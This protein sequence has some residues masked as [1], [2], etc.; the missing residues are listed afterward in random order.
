MQEQLSS[1]PLFQGMSRD[2]LADVA[3]WAHLDTRLLKPARTI[4]RVGDICRS[5]IF[6]A[7]GRF[8]VTT[9]AMGHTYQITET[10]H[11]PEVI[12]PERV[13]GLTQ[14]YSRTYTA[15]TPTRIIELEKPDML[16]LIEKYLVFRLNLL[17]LIS[18][19][20]QK[21][22]RNLWTPAPQT[23]DENILHFVAK[24]CD[25]PAGSIEVKTKMTLLA[26]ELG[27]S[28]LDVSNALHR[29]SDAGLI[30][31]QRGII[32]IPDLQQALRYEPK[33]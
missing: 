13:F 8:Q 14:Q 12:E 6:V 28:R 16:A 3:K 2:D 26:H 27:V 11:A 19:K 25:I 32:T 24:H 4:V 17:A 18:T 21:L 33:A 31:L 20:A 29:L 22:H 1:L 15:L 10:R 30:V 5:L 7:E 23:L 9:S